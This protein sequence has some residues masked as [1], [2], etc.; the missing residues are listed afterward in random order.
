MLET[1]DL[2]LATYK[3]FKNGVVLAGATKNKLKVLYAESGTYTVEVTRTG[4]CAG[5]KMSQTTQVNPQPGANIKL[6][7]A[8]KDYCVGE[9]F[10]I[11]V[12]GL[13]LPSGY[14]IF[15][16]NTPSLYHLFTLP[17]GDRKS[18]V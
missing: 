1:A 3:W 5:T 11:N 12:N 9:S 10:I 8:K 16:I 6:D 17:E 2:V 14:G 4:G 15:G 13:P 7:M 18:V